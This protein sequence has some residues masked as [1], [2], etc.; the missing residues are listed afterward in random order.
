MMNLFE[1]DVPLWQWIVSQVLGVF[2]IIV[3]SYAMLQKTKSKEL[4][5]LS[6]GNLLIA[7]ISLLLRNWMVDGCWY[8]WGRLF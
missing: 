3:F 5:W 2:A 7:I 4:A 6:S 8:C 1:I